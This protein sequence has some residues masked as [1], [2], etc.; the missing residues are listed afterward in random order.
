MGLP[1]LGCTEERK[2]WHLLAS[3]DKGRSDIGTSAWAQALQLRGGVS[4]RALLIGIE[5]TKWTV[6]GRDVICWRK[7]CKALTL[8][9]T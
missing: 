6:S 2:P 7:V 4:G 5:Q 9:D 8:R 3:T 1:G